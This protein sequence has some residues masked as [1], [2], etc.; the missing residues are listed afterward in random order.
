[1]AICNV[2]R[3]A[4]NWAPLSP[5]ARATIQREPG[6][7]DYVELWDGAA[8]QMNAFGSCR[9]VPALLAIMAD[10]EP[11]KPDPDQMSFDL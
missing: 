4:S 7:W 5:E 1:M 3:R 9:P 6:R 2:K 8:A 10:P 11:E